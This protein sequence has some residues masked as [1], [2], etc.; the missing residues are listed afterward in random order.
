M[1]VYGGSEDISSSASATNSIGSTGLWAWDSRNGS[2]YQPTVQVQGGAAMLPQI[3]FQASNL[4]S[5]GQIVALVG[6]TTG[7][8]ATGVLQKLDTNSWSW[9][10]PT[11]SKVSV[12][13]R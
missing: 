12:Q 9:S 10:F 1:I 8:L 6:N 11:S 7:G 3:Y 5:Q 13:G 4:P 2:W